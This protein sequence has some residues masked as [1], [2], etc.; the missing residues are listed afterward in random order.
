MVPNEFERFPGKMDKTQEQA[1][2]LV[3]E[4]H[5]L[6]LTGQGG[7]GK[8]Y[9]IR[10]CFEWLKKISKK[11]ALT[12]YTGIA[13]RQYPSHMGAMTLHRFCGLEDGR[14]SNNELV[15]LIKNDERFSPTKQR[16]INTDILIIDEVSWCQKRFFS[17]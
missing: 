14:H 3:V 9:T 16:I 4:G 7:T 11:T 2:N 1:K 6:V 15:N 17:R 10:S 8:T 13:C 5:N 12:C